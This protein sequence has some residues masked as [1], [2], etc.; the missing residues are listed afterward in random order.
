MSGLAMPSSQ[1]YGN[2]NFTNKNTSYKG[3]QEILKEKDA[4]SLAERFDEARRKSYTTRRQSG[5]EALGGASVLHFREEDLLRQERERYDA[6][7][8]IE[9][10]AHPLFKTTTTKKERRDPIDH[11]TGD[12]VLQLVV[13]VG[14]SG[15]QRVR[16]ELIRGGVISVKIPKGFEVGDKFRVRVPVSLKSAAEKKNKKD[17]DSGVSAP[18]KRSDP[19]EQITMNLPGQNDDADSDNEKKKKK[20]KKKDK[21]EKKEKKKKKKKTKSDPSDQDLLDFFG[22]DSSSNIP[23]PQSMEDMQAQLQALQMENTK[24]RKKN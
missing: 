17:I 9:Q 12:T 19:S 11:K 7:Q 5:L 13:P 18:I 14:V 24:L 10:N 1:M 4:E 3:K 2:S 15:G 6:E 22:D 23:P 20:K 8:L 21:K 16:I